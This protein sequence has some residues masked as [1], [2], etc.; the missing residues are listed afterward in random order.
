MHQK[1]LLIHVEG[2]LVE[3]P[4][5]ADSSTEIKRNLFVLVEPSLLHHTFLLGPARFTALPI[6]ALLWMSQHTREYR[7]LAWL[8]D[9]REKIFHS[10]D[11]FKIFT[12]VR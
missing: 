5:A 1:K 6:S 9:V 8:K 4:S 12:A 7:K 10:T 11:F 3:F 2:S